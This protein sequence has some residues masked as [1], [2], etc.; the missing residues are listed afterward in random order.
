[1]RLVAAELNA[2]RAVKLDD[3]LNRQVTDAVSR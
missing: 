3:V 1:M 2:D